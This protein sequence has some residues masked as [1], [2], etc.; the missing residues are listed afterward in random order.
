VVQGRNSPRLRDIVP[1]L[2][3]W[4]LVTTQCAIVGQISMSRQVDGLAVLFERPRRDRMSLLLF[5]TETWYSEI[6]LSGVGSR[7]GSTVR[8]TQRLIESSL[9]DR[10]GHLPTGGVVARRGK[11]NVVQPPS[12]TLTSADQRHAVGSMETTSSWFRS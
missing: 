6:E 1:R 7:E 10:T 8:T 4:S 2:I 11:M 3:H 9:V 12:A 5:P